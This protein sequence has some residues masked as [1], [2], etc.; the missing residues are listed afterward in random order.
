MKVTIESDD[1][2]TQSSI[3]RVG[4]QDLQEAVRMLR[5]ALIGFGYHSDQVD[6]FLITE[7][8]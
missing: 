8:G 6:W 3:T 7:E 1:R 5:D 2:E 4:G